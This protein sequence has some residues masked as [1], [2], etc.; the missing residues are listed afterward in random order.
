MISW[1]TRVHTPNGISIGSAVFRTAHDRDR[2]TDR[3]TDHSASVTISH[4]YVISDSDSWG[5][6]TL[7]VPESQKPGRPVPLVFVAI[8]STLNVATSL[9]TVAYCGCKMWQ[10]AAA[11]VAIIDTALP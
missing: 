10:G 2:Q 7:L 1:L 5:T 4:I 3:Q 9:S 6:N 11:K 8:A